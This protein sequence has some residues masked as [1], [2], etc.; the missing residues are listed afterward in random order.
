MLHMKTGVGPACK[1][2]RLDSA[3]TVRN[4]I[5]STPPYPRYETL[6]RGRC[7]VC[8]KSIADER[9][10]VLSCCKLLRTL[11]DHIRPTHPTPP[12]TPQGVLVSKV[13]Q[14]RNKSVA[15]D[16][17]TL[18]EYCRL[19]VTYMHIY[20]NRNDCFFFSP[21]MEHW[22][23]ARIAVAR[24]SPTFRPFVQNWLGTPLRRRRKT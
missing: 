21:G 1:H 17:S 8:V 22:S 10:G 15:S 18:F 24:R 7:G 19:T 2:E 3:Q 12:L 9:P 4:V 6:A 16:P 23:C 13:L 20:I 11:L 14:V 5:T